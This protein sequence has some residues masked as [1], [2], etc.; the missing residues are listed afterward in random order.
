M[1]CN[2]VRI[3]CKITL[4]T[5]VPKFTGSIYSIEE[6]SCCV[7]DKIILVGIFTKNKTELIE[8]DAKNNVFHTEI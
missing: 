8:Y 5:N 7:G 4:I 1:C 3:S 6:G 2:F